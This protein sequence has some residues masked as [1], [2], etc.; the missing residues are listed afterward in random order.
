MIWSLLLFI[1]LD[2]SP[3]YPLLPLDR[4]PPVYSVTMHLPKCS[5]FWVD[6]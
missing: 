5:P 1:V 6:M 4:A 2:R 3:L